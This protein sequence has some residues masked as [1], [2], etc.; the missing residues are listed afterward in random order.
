MD[1][2]PCND[3]LEYYS[4]KTDFFC[5]HQSIKNKSQNASFIGV[6][7]F[8]WNSDNIFIF[9][10]FMRANIT[11]A[12]CLWYVPLPSLMVASSTSPCRAY[13][14]ICAHS[15]S[16]FGSSPGSDFHS[17]KLTSLINQR[18]LEEVTHHLPVSG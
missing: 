2:W 3:L 5:T 9:F 18:A 16:F 4:F 15:S 10:T 13:E 6:H 17:R 1:R 12:L 8:I 7:L 11:L 14:D